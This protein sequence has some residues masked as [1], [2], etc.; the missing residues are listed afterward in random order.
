MNYGK[1]RFPIL[2]TLTKVQFSVLFKTVGFWEH[3]LPENKKVITCFGNITKLVR[4]NEQEACVVVLS[5]S[6]RIYFSCDRVHDKLIKRYWI[7]YLSFRLSDFFCPILV[8]IYSWIRK[9]KSLL[10]I[11]Q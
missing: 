6:I 9:E 5:A 11:T 10:I 2:Y 3:E 7:F 1:C 8:L 4:H